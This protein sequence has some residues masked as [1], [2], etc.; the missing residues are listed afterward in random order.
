MSEKTK[1]FEEQ[2]DFVTRAKRDDEK[3]IST[4]INS[5][6]VIVIK[7]GS[8]LV[9]KN[10]KINK[11][12]IERFVDFTEALWRS[13]RKILLVSSGAVASADHPIM[14]EKKRD[15]VTKHALASIGQ[16][17]LMEMYRKA[18]G[19]HGRYVGQILF[20]RHSIE[21]R[22]GYLNARQTI[23]QLLEMEVVPIINENDPLATDEIRLGENDILG[24]LTAGLSSADLYIIFSD[25][26]GFYLGLKEKE[27]RPRKLRLVTHVTESLKKEAYGKGSRH[28]TG[29]M[30]TKLEAIE[31][32]EKFNI[33]TLIASGNAPSLYESVF[34]KLEGTLFINENSIQNLLTDWQLQ[35][36][37]EG[38]N[39]EKLAGVD[40]TGD[41]NSKEGKGEEDNLKQ[42]KQMPKDNLKV[43]KP[44][45]QSKEGKKR[46]L[47]RSSNKSGKSENEKSESEKSKKEGKIGKQI[48]SPREEEKDRGAA[49]FTGSKMSDVKYDDENAANQSDEKAIKNTNIRKKTSSMMKAGVGGTSR[50][51]Q[52]ETKKKNVSSKKKWLLSH[53]Q[54][55]GRVFIDEGA[56]QAMKLNK[57]LLAKGIKECE[58]SF[59]VGDVLDIVNEEGE[60]IARGVTQ[61]SFE[62]LKRIKGF[63]SKE[64]EKLLGYKASQEVIHR[65]HLVLF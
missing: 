17:S 4:C 41:K 61:F 31:L 32:G 58:G 47:L 23:L 62:E 24:A 59:R 1:N 25:V 33:P 10:G 34:E 26:D 6:R 44:S 64:F 46:L 11:Q 21:S 43:E 57:S 29:G 12:S 19:R 36:R 63:S 2:K 30:I 55:V 28:A 42:K 45:I 27:K 35:N 54:T 65:S 13:G 7:L 20:S 39:S 51:N 50:P 60:K 48:Q 9:A 56:V 14:W 8:S 15:Q 52:V 16:V 18:F 22:S 37:D 53:G 40:E 38:D 3:I 5:A 49:P